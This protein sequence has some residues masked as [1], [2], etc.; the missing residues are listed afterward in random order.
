MLSM[1]DTNSYYDEKTSL[2][3]P[4]TSYRYKRMNNHKRKRRT[5]RT[6]IP[7]KEVICLGIMLFCEGYNSTFLYSFIGYMILDFKMVRN[8]E[9]TGYYAGF[10][11][12]SYSITQ[13]FSGIAFGLI[14][15][16][17]WMSKRSIL[18]I[19]TLGTIVST[20]LFG[21]SP[22]FFFA[23]VMRSLTGLLNG[24]IATTKS[25]MADITDESNQNLAFSIIGVFWC[26][27]LVVGPG[28]G[29][30]LARPALKYP[31][32]FGGKLFMR[33]PYLLPCLF[34]SFIMVIAF[35]LLLFILRKNPLGVELPDE[36]EILFKEDNNE[37][38]TEQGYMENYGL[39]FKFFLYIL[40][41]M[42]IYCNWE[43]ILVMG[44]FAVASMFEIS[45]AELF[46]LWSMLSHGKGG[47]FFSTKECGIY[48]GMVGVWMI[49]FQ[50]F[51]YPKLATSIGKIR[52]LQI[53]YIC[54]IPLAFTP[55]LHFFVYTRRS[56]LWI[57]LALFALLRAIA[58]VSYF[59]SLVILI[60]N[61]TPFGKSG[62][63]SS[64]SQSCIC[65]SKTVTPIIV[66]S[67]FAWSSV[68]LHHPLRLNIP[69]F[70]CSGMVVVV[71]F[72]TILMNPSLD[73]PQQ[74]SSIIK[75]KMK[76]NKQE[77]ENTEIIAA[78]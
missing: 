16:L 77:E 19:G 36:N 17:G 6:P 8:E 54:T 22:N 44:N 3:N 29:G 33:F 43:I 34:C 73:S 30:I 61:S 7:K 40:K 52:C 2:I 25:Y 48:Q 69:F 50:A 66:G 13:F 14:G 1:K 35:L 15:D 53:G 65:F 63:Y 46:P 20:L 23:L 58:S 9:D 62:L 4:E 39:C 68:S 5:Y 37:S 47:L 18:L 60:N 55:Q 49:F 72:S 26:V 31:S 56:M 24:N 11:A 64:I 71:L 45:Q 51:I 41:M 76:N 59:S 10:V 67:L 57:F 12:S 42:K 28:L 21:L 74:P 75:S 78:A 38:V 32:I 27:G 70:L